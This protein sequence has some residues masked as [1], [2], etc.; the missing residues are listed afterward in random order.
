[1]QHSP[2]FSIII[3]TYNVERYIARCL[4][5]CINQTFSDIEILVVDD[6][7]SDDS[8]KIA[9]SFADKDSRIRIIHN[10]RNLG[11]FGARL[12]GEKE[13]RGEYILPL[14][15][16]DYI[17]LCTCKVLYRAITRTK[18]ALNNVNFIPNPNLE[19]LLMGGGQYE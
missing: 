12:S 7:G 8:I 6:C 16:D 4:E 18:K 13:A 14:D 19:N 15:S 1:M 10:P 9:Q 3:P 17:E 2:F 5:S 11:L